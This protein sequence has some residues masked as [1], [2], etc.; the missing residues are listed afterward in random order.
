M[1]TLLLNSLLAAIARPV[2][3]IVGMIVVLGAIFMVSRMF[4]YNVTL[5]ISDDF[6]TEIW[7]E[8]IS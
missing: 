3:I 4:T 6:S 5:H 7:D 8:L 1:K 2:P